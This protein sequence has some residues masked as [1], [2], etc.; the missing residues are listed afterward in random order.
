MRV[1]IVCFLMALWVKGA[2]WQP[3]PVGYE[4]RFPR[5]HGSHLAQKVEWWYFTGNLSSADGSEYGYQLTFFRI[6]TDVKPEN[7]SAWTV[8][9][10]H[11]A[12]FALSEL[13]GGKYHCAQRLGRAGPGLAGAAP[14]RLNV[15]NGPWLAEMKEDG[16][17]VLRADCKEGERD[18]GLE[19]TLTSTRPVVL[20]GE[21]GY[22][23]KGQQP[24]NASIYYSFTRMK[25]AGQ[26]RIGEATKSV[27]G[28]SWMDHEFG[29][30]FLE[31]GQLG[32]DWFSLQLEDGSDLMLFQIRQLN[33]KLPPTRVG[34]LIKPDGT[35]IALA[36]ADIILTSGGK[37]KSDWSGAQYPLEWGIQV[38][39]QKMKLT[40][41]TRLPNQEMRS[42]KFGPSYWEGAVQVTGEHDGRP[43][44]GRGYLEMTGYIGDGLRSFF[45][46][47]EPEKTA[48]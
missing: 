32:W 45:Q 4:L 44:A 48:K 12:H 21:N 23:R 19:L 36:A 27:S 38:P 30:S 18:F 26:I 34:T 15:W 3:A 7:P 43:T 39:S 10:L 47:G 14:D 42:L 20:Q 22:S 16:S 40:T 5:D 46:L 1:V 41:K 17:M 24:G 6:G 13:S 35:K 2:E 31:P 25:T 37:W 33:E 11:M 8:R 28:L 9:D 29:S